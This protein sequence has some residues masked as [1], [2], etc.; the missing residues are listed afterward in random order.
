MGT[1]RRC[2]PLCRCD[3]RNGACTAAN[4]PCPLGERCSP[5][6]NDQ[7]YGVCLPP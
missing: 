7:I 6:T 2:R 1:T 4:G 3:S 5:L